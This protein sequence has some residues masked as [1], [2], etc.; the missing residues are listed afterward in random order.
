MSSECDMCGLRSNS[1][2]RRVLMDAAGSGDWAMLC[3]ACER[4]LWEGQVEAKVAR[5][6]PRKAVAS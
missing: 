3:P 4:D 5:F 1:D 6:D 2:L